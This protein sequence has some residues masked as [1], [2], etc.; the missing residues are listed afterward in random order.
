MIPFECDHCVFIKITG[1]LANQ[2][3][4]TADAYLL[5]CIRRVMLDAF[6]SR[7]RSTVA[8]NTRLMRE[9]MSMAANLG[10]DPPVESPGPLPSFDHCG[11]K[12]AIMMV[13]KST[14]PGRHSDSHVQWDTIRK[15][16]STISNQ[17]RASRISNF[18]SWS[19]TD[20]KGTGYDRLT[21][22]SCGS[23]WFHRFS[24]GCRKRMG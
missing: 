16:R 3:N 2:N 5:S 22:E 15:Y 17:S 1:R 20:Y 4:D 7:A 19:M 23:L 18:T 6:W 11:Y 24:T 8:S 21:S 13:A 12:V 10:F 9:M 14:R